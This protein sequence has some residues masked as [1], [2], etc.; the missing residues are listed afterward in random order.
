MIDP[1]DV[2]IRYV[3]INSTVNGDTT[4]CAMY[5]RPSKIEVSSLEVGGRVYNLSKAA[6][7]LD[8]K[9]AEFYGEIVKEVI[10]LEGISSDEGFQFFED[11]LDIIHDVREYDEHSQPMHDN[12]IA[13]RLLIE[14][15]V[16]LRQFCS[17]FKL[18]SM[19]HAR[20][21]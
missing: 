9:V 12:I 5:H 15:L 11:V 8:I 3:R 20:E 4:G 21:N 16:M 13:V 17:Q 1:D 18:Q 10:P 2:E 19:K 14:E 7:L 6:E